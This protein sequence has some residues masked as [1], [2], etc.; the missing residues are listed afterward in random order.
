MSETQLLRLAVFQQ[1]V[2]WILADRTSPPPQIF[3]DIDF[4]I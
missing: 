2:G 3:F 1:F 4:N